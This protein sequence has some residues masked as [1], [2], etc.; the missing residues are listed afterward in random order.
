MVAG[1][2]ADLQVVD[3]DV[4]AGRDVARREADHLAVLAYRRAR[5]HVAHRDLVPAPHV[6]ADSE[7]VEG[8]AHGQV[9]PR[10]R[11]IV[12]RIQPDHAHVGAPA[13]CMR[14]SSSV[15]SAVQPP[16]LPSASDDAAAPSIAASR[17]SSPRAIRAATVP[18]NTSPAPVWS[19]IAGGGTAGT[20]RADEPSSSHTPSAPH[21]TATA[22]APIARTDSAACCGLPAPSNAPHS[23]GQDGVT[24]AAYGASCRNRR[25]AAVASVSRGRKFGSYTKRA[26]LVAAARTAPAALSD[27]AQVMPDASTTAA[28]IPAA[29]T[30]AA[31]SCEAALPRR[32]YTNSRAPDGSACT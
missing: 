5:R 23:C 17:R 2:V 10:N 19:T 30:S 4:L 9:A 25:A 3:V 20:C 12:G 24:S 22:R 21:V 1:E 32:A 14:L 16:G 7:A 11:H 15:G 27:R 8:L 28:S 18:A 29:W 26:A 31:L 13:R 6:L